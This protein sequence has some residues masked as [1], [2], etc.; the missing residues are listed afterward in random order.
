MEMSNYIIQ[1][2]RPELLLLIPVCYLI[3]YGIKK[4]ELGIDK[5]IPFIL[6]GISIVL[7]LLYLLATSD[8]ETYK[9]VIL[10]IF[11]SITQ[12]IL[13]A[14]CSVYVNQLIK[15]YNKVE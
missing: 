14:G 2:I 7:S 4:S 9:D 11:T 15:Q 8:V 3:G 1:F 12:G 6:G 10:V 13:T 5:W